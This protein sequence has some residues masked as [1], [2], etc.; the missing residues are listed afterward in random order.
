MRLIVLDRDGVINE[1][2]DAF[3]K[4]PEQWVPVPGSLEAIAR[5]NR[6]GWTVAVATN[7]S[8]IARGYYD[9]AT[10]SAMHQK[11]QGL[12]RPLGGRVDWISTSPYLDHHNSPARKPGAG[13]L[14]AIAARYGCEL[15][16][17][18]FVG[19]TWGDVQA[20][21]AVG[22]QPILV[23]SGKGERTLASH[24]EDIAALNVP[25]H[26]NLATVAEALCP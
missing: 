14:R 23:R 20:A 16:G 9:H 6:A 13:M 5:L 7:Q 3:I 18:P 17:V 12:L 8:G 10:L 22:M 2:S 25:V 4:S 15:T 11:L 1:D 26:D 21:Q 24:A 19:D